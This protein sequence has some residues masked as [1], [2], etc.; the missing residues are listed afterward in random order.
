M[1]HLYKLLL[2]FLLAI[3]GKTTLAQNNEDA[4]SLIK[5][6]VQLSNQ[7]K[8]A[9]AIDKYNQALK[10]DP[11]NVYADYQLAY[12]LFALNKGKE[13]I[14]YIEKVIKANTALNA[15]A[16]DLLGNIY[17]KDNETEKAIEAYKEG[18]KIKPDYQ[19]LY[20][21]LG[22]VYFR[23]KQYAEAE[24][25]AIEAIKLDSKHAS[26]QR[27]YALVTFHQNKRV[28]ALLG[29]CSFIL[30]EPNTQRSAE[31]YNNIQH[32]LQGGV[33]K[34]TNGNTTIPVSP[35]EAKETASLNMVITK[36]VL[37]G[38]T[39]K[40]TG[41][42][43]LEFELKNIFIS[44]GQ[45]SEKK[46][47]KSFFDKF[48]VDYFYKLAQSANMPAFTRL[49]SSSASK[50]EYAKWAGN[51]NKEVVDLDSWVKGTERGF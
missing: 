34:E 38:Q 32:I 20:Y 7:A 50:E 29:L 36:T 30:L 42:D 33:L 10:I 44:A 1:K 47:D 41:I 13:A 5:E 21:N 23:V 14:P 8:Y 6:G 48:F 51:H 26:S 3:V 15:G 12:S 9:E 35:T 28:P 46:T 27:M 45:L 40:L 43:L 25:Y 2:F 39:K 24:K 17:D 16:Y 4:N 19:R 18:I 11:A 31:A 22:L 49:V 37:S